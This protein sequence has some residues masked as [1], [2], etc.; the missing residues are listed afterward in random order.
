M[1]STFGSLDNARAVVSE[2]VERYRAN[3]DRYESSTYNEETARNEFINPL[4]EALGWDI[5]NKAGAAEQYK[6]VI[7]EESIKVGDFTTAPDYTFRFGGIRKF[8]VEAKK[9][10]VDLKTNPDSAY[11]LRRYAWSAKLPLSILTDFDGFAIY[12]TRIKPRVGDKAS[13]GR[14][15]Y[16]SFEELVPKLEEIW[17]IFS[18]D[19]VLKGSFDRYAE[20]TLGKRGTSEVDTE[21]LKDIE[22][23]RE[24]LA[25]NLALRNEDLTEDDLNFAVQSTIDRIIF[26]R[27][28]EGRGAEVYGGLLALTN[29]PHVYPR[30]VE[31]YRKADHRY[32]S[33]L[34]DFS[35]DGDRLTPGLTIDDKVLKPILANLYYPQSPYEFSVL[36][37]EIL[38]N[39]YEQFL[40]KVIRLTKGHRAVVEDKP[41]V[42][43]AGGV[44]YTP[45]YIVDYIVEQT[46]GKLTEGKSPKQLEQLRILDPACGSGSFLI[47]AYQHLLDAHLAWYREHDPQKH[48]KGVFLGPG[49]WRLATA[50]KRRILLNNI[51]GVDIDR[52]A[53]EVTKLSLL[54]KVMEGENNETLTQQSLF[55][56][57]ALPSLEQNIKCGNSLIGRD[58]FEGRLFPDTEQTKRVNAF[59]WKQEFSKILEDGGFNVIIGNPPYIRIHNLVDYYPFEVRF[60]QRNYETAHDGKVDIYLPFIERALSLLQSDGLMGFIVPN[61]FMQADYGANLRRLLT[62]KARL[63][64]LVDFGTA[65]VFDRATIYTCLVFLAGK[66]Q[67]NLRTRFNKT[68]ANAK[69]FLE[70]STDEARKPSEFGWG[71]WLAASIAESAV[72]KRLEAFP[73]RLA[74]L[75]KLSITGVKTGA[76][77]SFVFDR[78]EPKGE[79]V[80]A[81]PEGSEASVRIEPDLLVPYL[82]AESLKRYEILPGDRRLLY[83]YRLEGENTILIPEAE[84]TRAYPRTWQYLTARRKPLEGRQKGKLEGPSWYGLSFSSSLSM[85]LPPKIVTPTLSP[86]NAFALDKDGQFF[87]QGAG[88]GCGIVIEDPNLR[89]YL[90][91]VLNSALLTFYFQRISSP[92]QGDWYAYEPRY[93]ARIPI[94]LPESTEE[95]EVAGLAAS[96]RKMASLSSQRRAARAPHERERLGRQIEALK[97]EI[98]RIVNALYDVTADEES[99]IYTELRAEAPSRQMTS[100]RPDVQDDV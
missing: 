38:G 58:A 45:S 35:A 31:L 72:L 62:E 81:W 6:D 30:L 37:P 67:K 10:F 13:V 41:E 74:S 100:Q 86:V 92:F 87:P 54:L 12:D 85:F 4:F 94:V 34:F 84:M 73:T 68:H 56:E 23:W 24:E 80:D 50:E 16:L 75:A 57:R 9:P 93:L 64:E 49:G 53:V 14:V 25:K 52:Q 90:I 42:K 71:P 32:N 96:A 19:A 88:G 39:V 5:A 61:K 69:E 8:F 66:R 22:G 17:N 46:V 47:V 65:Q 99:V 29:G 27:I 40:G 76:N 82:K 1:Q 98:D 28:A 33:G 78:V 60:I 95:S 2:L 70:G 18:K 63:C 55:G 59:D 15:L 3:R 48:K 77:E 7:H 20:A 79:L 44:Y 97:A 21:F 51:F 36:P 11:Q 43:K 89:D 83:P 26:M 91:A